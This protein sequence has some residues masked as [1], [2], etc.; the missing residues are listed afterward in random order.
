MLAKKTT[1]YRFPT[2]AKLSSS[3]VVFGLMSIFLS[4]VIPFYNN[5]LEFNQVMKNFGMIEVFQSILTRIIITMPVIFVALSF[6][7]T[8]LALNGLEISK[9]NYFNPKQK[10]INLN[11]FLFFLPLVLVSFDKHITSGNIMYIITAVLFYF[12]T[13]LYTALLLWRIKDDDDY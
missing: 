1:K 5:N 6:A 9:D 11:L 10:T 8:A 4:I 7:I 3:V 2:F 13:M 12:F